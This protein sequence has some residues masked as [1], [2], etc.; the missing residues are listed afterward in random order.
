MTIES[1]YNELRDNALVIRAIANG[2]SG[3][4][5]QDALKELLELA[6]EYSVLQ[7]PAVRATLAAQGAKM[8]SG[9]QRWSSTGYSHG[10]CYGTHG[11]CYS[12]SSVAGE[13]EP[14]LTAAVE[15]LQARY[16]PL[17]IEAEKAFEA[18]RLAV[19]LGTVVE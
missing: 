2:I 1:R 7:W 13:L 5:T 9:P 11:V 8:P 4:L 14:A 6:T 18:Y 17:A 16:R 10:S 12:R 3:S 15:M 19:M